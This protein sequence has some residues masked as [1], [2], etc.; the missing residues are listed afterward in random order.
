MNTLRKLCNPPLLA[1]LV[2]AILTSGLVPDTT[3]GQSPE[4][5][6]A[7]QLPQR[8]P[9]RFDTRQRSFDIP[10]SAG[11]RNFKIVEVV[12]FV[13]TDQGQTW[14]QYAK[15]N[16][17]NG[18]FRFVCDRDGDYCFALQTIDRDGQRRPVQPQRPELKIVVDTEQPDL[19]FQV[20]SDA[21]GRIVG[22]W[23]AVDPNLDPSTLSIAYQAVTSEPST[24]AAW[25]PVPVSSVASTKGAFQSQ[26]A[27]WPQSP[28]SEI[29]VRAGVQDRAGNVST[30]VRQVTVTR[31]SAAAQSVA[32]TG[33]NR[34]PPTASV[35]P[36]GY[37]RAGIPAALQPAR[38]ANERQRPDDPPDLA[39][40]ASPQSNP[41]PQPPVPQKRLAHRLATTT[42]QSSELDAMTANTTK[43]IATATW[44]RRANDEPA[45]RVAQ[46]RTQIW[47]PRVTPASTSS[48]TNQVIASGSTANSADPV[49]A[50]AGNAAPP[51]QTGTLPAIARGR[52]AK[53][54]GIPGAMINHPQLENLKRMARASNSTHFQ[55]EY[56]I[57][58][59]GPE[60]VKSVEL[61]MT[62]D[63]GKNWRRWTTDDDLR[64]PMD[65]AV[66]GE[67]IFGFRIVVI[68]NEGLRTRSPRRND[69]ADMWV[70]V[71]TTEPD[72]RIT[73]APYGR[74]AEAG[75]LLI[76][77]SA[78]DANLALRPIKL[79]YSPRP[80]GPW[81]T[82]EEGVRNNGQFAWKP[83]TEIPDR[84]Y[85]R[86]EARD[87]AGNIGTHQLDRPIDVSGLI[88]RGHIR[89]I[90]PLGGP[91]T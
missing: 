2:A 73:A 33:A 42:R 28:T 16:P 25:I 34:A 44:K 86:L 1:G 20:R 23:T 74:D 83:G 38:Q 30:I 17:A 35:Q 79:M 49:S 3:R 65:V 46:H 50:T 63:G 14:R 29:R 87:T 62:S 43:S 10:F 66:E 24:D 64:S 75:K 5:P 61:W 32:G 51:S 11:S 58:A 52:T 4:P 89:G 88:P 91:S 39:R 53:P 70:N 45:A 36:R 22:Q 80:A 8:P 6:V 27:W 40:Q 82:I 19:Q 47:R 57:D 67:G 55:L 7:T 48:Q 60:G 41:T 56:E 9:T 84:I 54:P 12:L 21:A 59:V 77:W 37:Q 85:L 15:Q 71:D 13:S 31:P 69:P 26:L 81:T 76:Q 68:S 18:Q 72:A 78:N 90:T